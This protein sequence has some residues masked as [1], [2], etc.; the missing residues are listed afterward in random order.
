MN[1][2][3]ESSMKTHWLAT[4]GLALALAANGC[5][6]VP[7]A[8]TAQLATA[9]P[10]PAT[11]APTATSAPPSPTPVPPTPVPPTATTAVTPTV[12]ATATPAPQAATGGFAAGLSALKPVADAMAAAK[13]YRMTVTATGT[14]Q[15]QTGTF[16]V[17]VVKPDRLHMKADMGGQAFESI[18][19]GADNYV[20]LGGKWNK[21]TANPLPA[22]GMIL[23]S[24]PQK[25]LGQMNV[26][27]QVKGSVTKGGIDQ[28]DGASC[29]EWIWTPAD[30]SQTGGSICIGTSNSLP[31]QFKTADGK[32]VAKYSAWNVAISIEPPAMSGLL[33]GDSQKISG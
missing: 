6:N 31:L 17:E 33:P 15:N 28:I 8:P 26:G 25:I 23:S 21:M 10:L 12:A 27:T 24:D 14:G 7:A 11:V 2:R 32:V 4:V 22:S 20:K 9:V 19:I 16:V 13:S 3:G 5:S 18:T 30:T 1:D 29:Q